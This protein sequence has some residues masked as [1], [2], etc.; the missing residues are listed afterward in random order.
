MILSCQ[1]YREDRNLGKAYNDAFKLIG[2][3]DY[4]IITDY[5]VLYLLPDQIKHITEYCNRFP[6]GDLFVSWANRT[7]VPNAQIYS[8][9]LDEEADIR[10]HLAT[11]QECY[12]NL[13]NVTRIRENISG[14][15][16]AI[17]K[18]T[19]N[20][21]PFTE[22]LK[23]LGVDTIFSQK[24]LSADKIIYRMDGIYIWHTYRLL[25]GVKNKS[26]LL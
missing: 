15:L 7:F 23:C 25:N 20:E 11:A 21:I 16:M 24:L 5:D 8:G 12:K 22:D 1:P 9:K 3:D 26:H 13:Y 18:R 6:D 4:L 10:K 19:W 17:P 14:F 2:D